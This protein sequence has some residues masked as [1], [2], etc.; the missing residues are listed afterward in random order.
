[1]ATSRG[2]TRFQELSM[3]TIREQIEANV[4][5]ILTPDSI[6]SW[7]S[8]RI[9]MLGGATP[10][11]LMDQGREDEVLILSASYLNPSYG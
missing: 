3:T 7:W 5:R 10:Q 8:L 9:P 2:I 6:P 11:E 1:M 4:S